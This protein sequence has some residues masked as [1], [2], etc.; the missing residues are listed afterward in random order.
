MNA[1][2]R[3]D[4]NEYIIALFGQ[5]L[6]GRAVAKALVD[7]SRTQR[8][9]MPLHWEEPDKRSAEISPIEQRLASMMRTGSRVSIVWSAGRA[10]FFSSVV[11]T[12]AEFAIFRDV[13]H[14]AERLCRDSPVSHVTF[15]LVSS[16][17]GLFEGQRHVTTDALAAPQRPYGF[18]KLAEEELVTSSKTLS[19]FMIYRVTSAYGYLQAGARSGFVSKLISDSLHRGITHIS[20]TISTLRDFVFADD[21]GAYIAERVL[22][23]DVHAS[24]VLLLARNRPCSLLEVQHMVEDIVGR[25]LYVSYSPHA[26]NSADITFAADARLLN[27]QPSDLRSNIGAIY[28]AALTTGG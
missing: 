27:W 26:V 22:D 3:G 10:G 11:E 24:E 25:R 28:R 2:R 13:L 16:A 12:D 6:I 17:G 23:P 19:N 18:L 7:R 8:I 5:G 14:L 9:T 4:G 15:H 1:E 21:I 20:G